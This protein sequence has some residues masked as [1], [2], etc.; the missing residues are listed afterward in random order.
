MSRIGLLRTVVPLLASASVAALMASPALAQPVDSSA[1]AAA[2]TVPTAVGPETTVNE[3]VVTGTR[4]RGVAP[5]G[6]SLIQVDRAAM[7]QSGLS[8]TS[9]ILYTQPSVLVLGSG[10]DR[11]GGASQQGNDLNALAFNKSPNIHGLGPGATLSLLNGHRVPHEGANMNAFDA[12]NIPEQ[13][14][15]RVEIVADG[16]S[17]VYGADAVAGTVNYVLRAPANTAEVY[18]Q[19]GWA[20][21]REQ[22]QATGVAGFNWGSGGIIASYQHTKFTALAASDRP[23]LYSDDYSPYGGP[24]SGDFSAPGNVVVGGVD[25]AIPRNQNGQGL[26][27]SQLGPAGQPNRQNSWTGYDATPASVRDTVAGNL[28]QKITDW[29]DVFADGF[30]TNR[31]YGLRYISQ[32][33]KVTLTIPNSNFYSPCN[34]SFAGAPAALVA[35]C[36]TGSLTVR[37]NTLY[38]SGPST[39]TGYVRGWSVNGGLHVS[40]PHDWKAT[41]FVQAGQH[42]ELAVTRYFLSNALPT[43]PEL[44]GTTA[45]TAFNPF[46]DSS[47]GSCNP[48]SLNSRIAGVDLRT[49]TVDKDQNIQLS[50]DGALFNLPGGPVR[51]AAGVE[52]YNEVFIN[53]N[54]F[55]SSPAARHVNSVFAE[56]YIPIVGEMNAMPGIYRLE[57]DVAGRIDK[58]SDVGTTQ[59]PKIGL[60]WSPFEDLKIHGSFGTSFRAPGLVDNNPFAQHGYIPF[61]PF[62]GSV[63]TPSLCPACATVPGGLAFYSVIGGANGDLKPEGARTYSV[64]GDFA[65][66]SLPGFTASINYWWVSYKGQISTAV[67]N[68]GPFQAVNLQ[69]YNQYQIYNPTLFPALAA[70]NPV[71]FF[72]AFPTVN[73]SNPSC[74]AVFGKAVTTQA[75][76][77][78][79]VNCINTGGDGGLFGPPAN[80]ANV[81]S[82]ASGHRINGSV[83]KATGLDLSAQYSWLTGVGHLTVGAVGEL[84]TKWDVAPVAGAPFIDENNQFGY[85]LRFKARGT[86]GWSNMVGPGELSVF[87]FLNYSNAYH[88]DQTLLPA[89]VGAQYTHINAYTTIDGTIR[90]N[91]GSAP[92]EKMLRNITLTFSVQNLFNSRPPLVINSSGVGGI[93][94]DPANASPLQ[95]TFQ[96]QVG[97]KF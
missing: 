42:D 4:I 18:G 76:F 94:F 58:Y 47:L 59:N 56:A 68:A 63:V 77:N 31:D 61:G 5:V 73:Q 17:A 45:A 81:A 33:T 43:F 86:L 2:S 20:D 62:P 11:S 85:P 9:D 22:W 88:I 44:A 38:D 52:R 7:E 1:P 6:S 64:G 41:F 39:R 96:V 79:L 50:I 21:G 29:L 14:L 75:L 37:Y 32:G 34:N 15:Q 87:G 57:L 16:G 72:G 97:K 55:G 46:C 93:L 90:Y 30:Y 12:D 35:A 54:N 8:S 10:A 80:P 48:D 27:L 89:G 25:Y 49:L 91:T 36:N 24:P 66:K 51:L 67:Y 83:T 65:P 26:L 82:I 78:T 95:R 74:A 3:L 23:W 28:T 70:N 53:T 40:L 92:S 84:I 19:Y 69:Y 60:N 71:A 13:L